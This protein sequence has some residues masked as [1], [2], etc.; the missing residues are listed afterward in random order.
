[1]VDQDRLKHLQNDPE[2][3]EAYLMIERMCDTTK[4]ETTDATTK[5]QVMRTF[6]VDELMKQS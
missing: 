4:W 3:R 2:E 6:V 1:M 5:Q